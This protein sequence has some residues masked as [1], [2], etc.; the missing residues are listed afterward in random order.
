MRLGSRDGIYDLT[1]LDSR[2]V[3]EKEQVLI[4]RPTTMGTGYECRFELLEPK[5]LPRVIHLLVHKV[6]LLINDIVG[7][8]DGY[9]FE[10][11]TR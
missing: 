7:L 10:P 6:V 5:F 1:S 4:D 8:I 2:W 11:T 3:E 9:L